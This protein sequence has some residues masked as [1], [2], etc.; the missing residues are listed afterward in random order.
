MGLFRD[1]GELRV[2]LPPFTVSGDADAAARSE[3]QTDTPEEGTA[4]E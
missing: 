4:D 2:I 1:A 3:H